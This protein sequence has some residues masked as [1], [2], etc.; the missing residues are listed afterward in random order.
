M[1][2]TPTQPQGNLDADGLRQWLVSEL[3]RIARSVADDFGTT[4]SAATVAAIQAALTT[5]Q[6]NITTLQ[7]AMTAAQAA[8]VVLQGQVA[9]AD[10]IATQTGSVASLVSTVI[11]NVVTLNVPIGTWDI[12]GVAVFFGLGATTSTESTA[13]LNAASGVISGAIPDID[14]DRYASTADRIRTARMGP[15]RVTFGAATNYFLNARATFAV[16]TYSV[17]GWMRAKRVIV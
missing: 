10:D 1:T 9:Q 8:I 4:A 11:S 16:S 12:D 3:Q 7:A 2:Y 5:A 14:S 13:A 17:T 6:G 15:T